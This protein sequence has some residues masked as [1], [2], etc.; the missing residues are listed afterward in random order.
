MDITRVFRRHMSRLS[1]GAGLNAAPT[2][3]NSPEHF[4]QELFEAISAFP[5]PKITL[6]TLLH[7]SSVL[8]PVGAVKMSDVNFFPVSHEYGVS[9]RGL[10]PRPVRLLPAFPGLT[11][12]GVGPSC[13]GFWVPVGR[14]TGAGPA[15]AI[16]PCHNAARLHK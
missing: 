3:A 5:G 2:S 1:G 9:L 12:A 7:E 6:V 10:G 13:F 4:Q 11:G 16:L 15:P 8:R 14:A